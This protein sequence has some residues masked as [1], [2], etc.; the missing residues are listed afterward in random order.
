MVL[1]RPVMRLRAVPCGAYP[2]RPATSQTC[3]RVSSRTRS[4]P[5]Y[6][7]ETVATETPAARAT[8]LIVI[9]GARRAGGWDGVGIQHPRTPARR[10]DVI[11]RTPRPSWPDA[12]ARA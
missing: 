4:L 12:G 9:M 1:V 5:V 11:V 10:H 3:T 2:S 7:R 6:T 8:S